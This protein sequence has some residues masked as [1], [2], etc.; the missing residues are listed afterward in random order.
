[1][2]KVVLSRGTLSTERFHVNKYRKYIGV[3]NVNMQP[4]LKSD[5]LKFSC[6]KMIGGIQIQQVH[7]KVGPGHFRQTADTFPACTTLLLLN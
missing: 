2:T 1:M 3:K 7:I 5:W 4:Q 6:I